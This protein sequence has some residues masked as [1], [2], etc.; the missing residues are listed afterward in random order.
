MSV[1]ALLALEQLPILDMP[2]GAAPRNIM[3]ALEG[4]D[5]TPDRTKVRFTWRLDNFAAFKTILET[6]KVFSR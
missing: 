3:A 6:R 2:P 5:V 1:C 4:Q